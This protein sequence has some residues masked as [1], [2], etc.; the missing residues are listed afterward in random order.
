VPLAA[1]MADGDAQEMACLFEEMINHE[2]WG[3]PNYFL[4]SDYI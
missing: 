2:I 1:A 4:T 3:V